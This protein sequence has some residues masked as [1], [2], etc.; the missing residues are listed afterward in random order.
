MCCLFTRGLVAFDLLVGYVSFGL[1]CIVWFAVVF[2][3]LVVNVV[4]GSWVWVYGLVIGLGWGCGFGCICLCWVYM[5]V[6]VFL[7]VVVCWCV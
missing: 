7:W 5:L 2:W 6:F 3:V 1:G 4:R